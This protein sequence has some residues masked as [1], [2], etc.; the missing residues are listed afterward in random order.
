MRTAVPS[1]PASGGDGRTDGVDG[2]PV[3]DL[4]RLPLQRRQR[5]D[6]HADER[7][8]TTRTVMGRARIR[9]TTSGDFVSFVAACPACGAD[10][11]WTEER[12]DTRL[13]AVMSC[14]CAQHAG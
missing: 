5:G 10:C 4:V 12:E 1:N 6:P 9:A 8:A 3:A 11:L 7:P 13:L 14:V 2:F